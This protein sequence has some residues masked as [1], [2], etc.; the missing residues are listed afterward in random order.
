VVI[1]DVP[2]TATDLKL[3]LKG[4]DATLRLGF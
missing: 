1:F 2:S 3:G 4:A